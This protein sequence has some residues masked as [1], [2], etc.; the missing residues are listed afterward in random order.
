[1]CSVKVRQSVKRNLVCREIGCSPPLVFA[2]L[3]CVIS[4]PAS[5]GLCKLARIEGSMF[6]DQNAIPLDGFRAKA[7]LLSE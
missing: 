5:V 1:M 2:C 7:R 3:K 6:L 4:S